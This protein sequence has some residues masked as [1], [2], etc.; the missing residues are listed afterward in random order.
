MIGQCPL[1]ILGHYEVALNTYA[2]YTPGPVD[3]KLGR[4]HQGDL[5]TLL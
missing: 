1:S 5:Y 2:S 4:K 3:S